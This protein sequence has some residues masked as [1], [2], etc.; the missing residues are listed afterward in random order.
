LLLYEALARLADVRPQ[1]A[2][3]VKLPFFASLTVDEVSPPLG[4]SSRTAR[5]LWA[6][7]QAW[8]RR[9]MDARGDIKSREFLQSRFPER[10]LAAFSHARRIVL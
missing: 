6:F 10:I 1:T 4:I 2:E 8:L 3:L 7:A 9:E 5:R